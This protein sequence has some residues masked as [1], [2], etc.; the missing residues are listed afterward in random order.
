MTGEISKFSGE[1]V[2][3]AL[4]SIRSDAAGGAA[5]AL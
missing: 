5:A 3:K 2:V 1:G 4:T